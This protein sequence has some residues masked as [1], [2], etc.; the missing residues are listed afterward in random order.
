MNYFQRI[1]N[2]TIVLVAVTLFFSF[3]FL[4]VNLYAQTNRK[5]QK[6]NFSTIGMREA[7]I[8]HGITL[9]FGAGISANLEQAL[10]IVPTVGIGYCAAQYYGVSNRFMQQSVTYQLGIGMDKG[11]YFVHNLVG[12]FH[13]TYI[14]R[15]DLNP[16]IYGI[17]MQFAYY[18]GDIYFTNPF[19][20]FYLRPEV[21]IAF[22]FKYK[23]K[24]AEVLRVT[25]SLMYG[26]NVKTIY[27][28]TENDP[29]CQKEASPNSYIPWT[30]MNHH[31]VTLR[32]NI[33]L[34]NQR[35]MRK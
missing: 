28:F 11:G 30:A 5:K 17:A 6:N 35:E 3:L 20:N 23:V 18:G 31:V 14:G 4:D 33:N 32:L 1:S 29:A 2:K 13:C 19:V 22:P 25:G 10:S 15:T 8:R 27:S 34:K 9:N 7:R 24:T 26:F 16:F 12:T 21:G